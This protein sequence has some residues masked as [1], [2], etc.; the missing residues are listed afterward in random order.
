MPGEM[1]LH[2]ID[3]AII[4]LYFV[5]VLGIGWALKR[6]MKTSLDFFE[7]GRS[8]AA[9]ITALA[10]ISANLGAQ[11]VIGMAASG[12]KYGIMTAHFYWV[13]AIPAM[14]FVGVFMMPFYYGSKAHSV[15]EYLRLR[16]DEKTRALNA[17]SF[18]VMTIFS[19]GISMYVMGRLFQLLLGWDI[20][21]SI[22]VSAVVVL[23]YILL[24]GLTS[25]IYNEVV[26]F[27]L[28]VF[29]FLPLVFLGVMGAGGWSGV[30]ARLATVA[31]E[32]GF[33]PGAWTESWRHMGSASSN[34][35]GIEW[36]GMVAGLGFVMSFGYWCTDFLVIQRAMAARSMNAA[37]RTPILAAIPKLLMP[38]IVILPG[39]V[40]LAILPASAFQF[41]GRT[42]YNMVMPLMLQK[43]YPPGLLGLG[44][45]ALLAS[46]MSGMAGN[47]TAFNTV[48]TY[49]IYKPYLKSDGDDAHYMRV[50]RQATVFGTILSVATAY[51]AM[52][53]GNINDLLQLVFSFINAPLFATFLL[54]MFWARSTA[55]GAFWGLL[56]GILACAAHYL[57]TGVGAD[58]TGTLHAYPSDMARNFW[59]AIYSWTTCFFV[60]IGVSLV[61][62]PRSAEDLNGLVYSMTPRVR[63]TGLAWYNR[64]VLLAVIVGAVALAINVYFW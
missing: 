37:Q 13:G 2:P 40:A 63:E 25:S 18:A 23:V 56:S 27:F 6:F 12:A 20:N 35:M 9:W 28:I 62:K 42:D 3:Y 55:N 31:T 61:T 32:A 30:E 21:V 24:G 26:Q 48:W 60:T 64:P 4:A 15:P 29:G 17:V 38:F 22:I 5:F 52:N 14:I 47:V 59:G 43:F 10:F 1:S 46:F 16:F 11:E 58:G 50:G 53:F 33:A 57:L 34:P 8:L 54:G 41:E 51:V 7:S 19:S 36:F 45:T 49:D 39:L 44:L